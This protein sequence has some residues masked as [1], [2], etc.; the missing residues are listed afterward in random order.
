MT[1]PL[2]VV[3]RQTEQFKSL[4]EELRRRHDDGLQILCILGVLGENVGGNIQVKVLQ[5]NFED[6]LE[7]FVGEVLV[8]G[9]FFENVVELVLEHGL[10]LDAV[11]LQEDPLSYFEGLDPFLFNLLFEFLPFPLLSH[12]PFVFDHFVTVPD[13]SQQVTLYQVVEGF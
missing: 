3:P 7:A 8:F 11:V 13:C 5:T 1:F 2:H 6:L 12:E 4:D 10:S 9:V